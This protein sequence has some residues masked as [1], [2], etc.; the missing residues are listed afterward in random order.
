MSFDK[1]V[2]FSI[3]DH[4][5]TGRSLKDQGTR[6]LL[7]LLLD[8]GSSLEMEEAEVLLDNL[9][10]FCGFYVNWESNQD[11]SREELLGAAEIAWSSRLQSIFHNANILQKTQ[12]MNTLLKDLMAKFNSQ[13]DFKVNLDIFRTT[14]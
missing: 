8:L 5:F 13:H 6:E 4:F 7:L 11:K 12:D 3:Y 10:E 9:L 1:I 2:G 14:C